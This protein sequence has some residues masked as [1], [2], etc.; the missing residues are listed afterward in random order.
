VRDQLRE[1]GVRQLEL[2]QQW[3]D[4]LQPLLAVARLL[5]DRLLVQVGE[6]PLLELDGVR[7]RLRRRVDQP[8]G[9]REV[10]VVV[11]ADLG[12]DEAGLVGADAAASD[13]QRFLLHVRLL[14]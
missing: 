1:V 7:P 4:V 10:A 3:D 2:G 5:E 14:G 8:L 12:D 6:A 13:R 11:E 9:Q